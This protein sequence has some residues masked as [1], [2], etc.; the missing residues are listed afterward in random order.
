[1]A[2][3]RRCS[4]LGLH[5]WIPQ[6]DIRKHIYLRYLSPL[7]RLMIEAAHLPRRD[8]R[9]VHLVWAIKEDCFR[10]FCWIYERTYF[11]INDHLVL[12]AFQ[13]RRMDVVE[14]LWQHCVIVGSTELT[15]VTLL[16]ANAGDIETLQWMLDHNIKPD[17]WCI[18]LGSLVGHQPSVL[19]WVASRKV[20]TD[21][22]LEKRQRTM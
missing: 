15:E 21:S 20:W 1:M 4:W 17:M 10:V 9:Q 6:K 12:S 16:A 13:W 18:A 19:R 2:Q 14:F 7:D 5:R 8:F 11:R 3:P 22:S